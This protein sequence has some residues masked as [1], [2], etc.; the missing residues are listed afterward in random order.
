MKIAGTTIGIHHLIAHPSGLPHLMVLWS[1]SPRRLSVPGVQPLSGQTQRSLAMPAP[2]STVPYQIM[3]QTLTCCSLVCMSFIGEGYQPL[4]RE[5][6]PQVAQRDVLQRWELLEPLLPSR[7]VMVDVGSNYGWFGLRACL[8]R[9]ELRVLSVEPDVECARIQSEL[10]VEH[11]LQDRMEVL[12]R[13]V[14]GFWLG[15]VV[16]RVDLVLM[17]SVLHWFKD[18]VRVVSEAAGDVGSGCV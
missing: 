2:F 13:P 8:S 12:T 10:V 11:G 7:G 3:Y 17:L 9:P 14:D 1:G 18:P 15:E 5:G 6:V 16:E 4:F